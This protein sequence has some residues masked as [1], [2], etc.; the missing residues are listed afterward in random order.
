MLA[1]VRLLRRRPRRRRNRRFRHLMLALSAQ[2]CWTR[3]C[4]RLSMPSLTS[5]RR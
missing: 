3:R 5:A 4:S 1:G 2:S